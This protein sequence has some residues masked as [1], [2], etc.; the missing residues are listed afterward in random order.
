MKITE[1]VIRPVD[2]PRKDSFGVW[3]HQYKV[4][5]NVYV[6]IHTD[7]GVTGYGEAG[8]IADYFGETQETAVEV[9]RKYLAPLVIGKD[10]LNIRE[11][12]AE[13]DRALPRNP[14]AK[15]SIDIALHDLKGKVL[16]VPAWS[17][18][19]GRAQSKIP[20]TFVV[21]ID[22]SIEKM[23]EKALNGQKA[24]F[25]TIKV[26]GGN[27]IRQDLH[28]LRT[29]RQAMGQDGSWLRLD[30]NTGYNNSPE[31][32]RYVDQLEALKVVLLEQPF[33]AEEWEA[34]RALRNRIRTPIL[35]DESMQS[36]WAM[37]Q[38]ARSPE[39]FVA[40]IKVQIAGGLLKASQLVDAAQHFRIPVMIGSH[41]E[42]HVGNTA[43]IHLASLINK[44]DYTCDQR[45]AFA[46][47]P[48]ADVVE[49][50]PRLD[51]P[52]VAVPDKPGLGI[53]VN[54]KKTEPLALATYNIK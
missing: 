39:G 48:D 32:W 30:A 2:I 24:G 46:V 45:Y 15:A 4:L 5:P 20:L 51:V 34:L 18:L 25:P 50:S 13:L 16:G 47:A 29:M 23:V 19:G 22:S 33:P 27:D 28:H 44:M 35:L 12:V 40:N 8:P 31:T 1:V 10:P 42:S 52:T 37:Q 43:S 41:R 26:K 38:L 53:A 3:R 54:W 11:R 14:C 49:D 9:L 17:L 36:G 7:D 21:G 6:A